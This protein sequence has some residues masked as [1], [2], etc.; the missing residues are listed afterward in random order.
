MCSYDAVILDLDGT[1]AHTAPGIAHAVSQTMTSLGLPAP[2]IELVQ[3]LMGGGAVKFFQRLLPDADPGLSDQLVNG[4][5]TYYVAHAEESTELYPGVRETLEALHNGVKL[6][7]C[8]AKTRPA[9]IRILD[10]FGIAQYFETVVAME[11]MPAPKPD[12]RSAGIAIERLGVPA[13]NTLFV[14]DSM[15]DLLTAQ[16]AG[17]DCWIVT[18]GYGFEAVYQAGGYAR[19]IDNFAL[20]RE[21]TTTE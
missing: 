4:F 9:A 16:N 10:H 18:Y 7:V 6:A 19:A 21:I 17:L 1:L 15:T 11:D 14:G 3:A 8:T 12:P 13:S 2:D 20:L 5:L